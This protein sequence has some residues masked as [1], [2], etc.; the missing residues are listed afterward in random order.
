MTAES[1]TYNDWE[2][3]PGMDDD[4][5]RSTADALLNRWCTSPNT[6]D[7]VDIEE[8]DPRSCT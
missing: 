3:P 2:V 1:A 8:L 4:D 6:A 7:D 5:D